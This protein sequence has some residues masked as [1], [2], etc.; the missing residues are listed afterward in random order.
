M[1]EAE[2]VA[3]ASIIVDRNTFNV[4][5]KVKKTETVIKTILAQKKEEELLQMF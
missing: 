1:I 4:E 3:R 2:K 5:G